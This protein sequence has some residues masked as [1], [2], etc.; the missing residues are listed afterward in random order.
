[1]LDKRNNLIIPLKKKSVN[2]H[3]IRNEI[4]LKWFNHLVN[5]YYTCLADFAY[6]LTRSRELSEEITDDVF[7]KIWD[8][9][10]E[11]SQI[12]NISSYLYKAIKNTS[13]NYLEKINRHH[14]IP[15]DTLPEIHIPTHYNTPE[16]EY[17]SHELDNGLA[18]A[19]ES[20]PEKCKLIFRLAKE[21]GLKYKEIASL[22]GLSEKTIENHISLALKKIM[23]CLQ[24][25]TDVKKPR[26]RGLSGLLS[27]FL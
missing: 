24:K 20:L 5:K 17:I 1:M 2:S 26:K 22:T 12:E 19:V 21:D 6:T 11:V 27:F 14:I 23:D 7:I 13:L 18:K 25:N 3:S 10:E 8:R 9:R 4:H 15:F 16:N